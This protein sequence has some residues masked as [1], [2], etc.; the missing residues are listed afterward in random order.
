MRAFRFPYAIDCGRDALD[1]RG[2]DAGAAAVSLALTDS[3]DGSPRAAHIV[4]I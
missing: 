4:L 1:V 2:A 3:I